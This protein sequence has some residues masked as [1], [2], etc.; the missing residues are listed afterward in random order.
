M[1]S[2]T[3]CLTALYNRERKAHESSTSGADHESEIKALTLVELVTYIEE[4]RGLEVCPVFRL[5]ALLKMYSVKL[6]QLGVDID[7]RPNRTRLKEM[8]F[9]WCQT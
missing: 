2:T 1:L 5:T 3:Q 9:K 7:T 6:T 4:T 8:L